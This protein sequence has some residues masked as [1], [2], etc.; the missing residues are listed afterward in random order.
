MS[1]TDILLLATG[2]F[3]LIIFSGL[4]L[5]FIISKKRNSGIP[6]QVTKN[7][8]QTVIPSTVS[9]S[10]SGSNIRVHKINNPLPVATPSKPVISAGKA[11]AKEIN[12]AFIKKPL[13]LQVLNS[14]VPEKYFARDYYS[15][16]RN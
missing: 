2:T 4:F 13:R 12:T 14:S 15:R 11:S 16:D 5:S 7:I 8:L 1:L 10:Y 6:A 3:F 9:A